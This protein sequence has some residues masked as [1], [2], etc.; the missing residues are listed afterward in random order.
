MSENAKGKSAWEKA[1]VFG[2][3]GFLMLFAA[4]RAADYAPLGSDLAIAWPM[5]EWGVGFMVALMAVAGAAAKLSDRWL[6]LR[7]WVGGRRLP[8]TFVS[9][10]YGPVLLG[11][12]LPASW[13]WVPWLSGRVPELVFALLAAAFFGLGCATLMTY[14]FG[15]LFREEK[16]AR[17]VRN[18]DA[19]VQLSG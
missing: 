3:L 2:I 12:A 18:G 13:Y 5:V 19:G 15:G 9:V 10:I 14:S 17:E 11:F 8:A 7:S 4:G 6:W 16:S 1:V